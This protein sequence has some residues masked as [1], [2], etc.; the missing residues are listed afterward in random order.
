DAHYTPSAPKPEPP[1]EVKTKTTS[2]STTTSSSTSKKNLRYNVF[3]T[4]EEVLTGCEKN[5]RY[6][7]VKNGEKETIQLKVTIPKGAYHQ[8]RLKVAEFGSDTGDLFVIVHW[9]NH[10]IFQ[11]DG[12]DISV[13]VPI[14]YLQA[15]EGSTI[16]IP[17]LSGV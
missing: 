8:Q 12:L 10:P 9:Q 14:N 2:R 16:E 17:T 11:V 1:P 15:A 5:I 4:L 6:L 13:N 7:R 3:V